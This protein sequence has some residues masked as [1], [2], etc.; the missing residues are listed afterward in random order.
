VKKIIGMKSLFYGGREAG[1]ATAEYAVGTVA[2]ISIGTILYKV[3]S[4][5]EFRNAIWDLILWLFRL[6]SGVTGG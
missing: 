3:I 4:S 5:P 6:I 2:V 1:M